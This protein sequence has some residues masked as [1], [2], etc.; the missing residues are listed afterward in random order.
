MHPCRLE[1]GLFT[2]LKFPL[3]GAGSRPLPV[4]TGAPGDGEF[5]GGAGDGE[6]PGRPSG[7]LP[8]LVATHHWGNNRFCSA[9]GRDHHTNWWTVS[10]PV[11]QCSPH[12]RPLLSATFLRC[13]DHSYAAPPV[14][15][16]ASGVILCTMRYVAVQPLY[17][18]RTNHWR[19]H[20]HT[21]KCSLKQCHA[22]CSQVEESSRRMYWCG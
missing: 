12:V 10:N 3:L 2:V 22:R 6:I 15:L 7:W 13:L 1:R 19:S 18:S 4:S 16:L 9:G 8:L 20:C 14:L 5:A 17:H 11:G 21:H